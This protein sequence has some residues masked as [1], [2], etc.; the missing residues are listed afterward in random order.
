VGADTG[1]VN[2]N[3]LEFVDR[4]AKEG[5]ETALIKD[6]NEWLEGDGGNL[7]SSALRSHISGANLVE[8]PLG[9]DH[10]EIKAAFDEAHPQLEGT[11]PEGLSALPAGAGD[12]K[13]APPEVQTE[14]KELTK[15]QKEALKAAGLSV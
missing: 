2:Y 12:P 7:V 9:T 6:I 13:K 8:L 5:D 15:E 1:K 11:K 4:P 10:A 14:A 3:V